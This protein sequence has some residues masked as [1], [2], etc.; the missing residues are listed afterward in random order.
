MYASLCYSVSGHE[1]NMILELTKIDIP[2]NGNI[3]TNSICTFTASLDK[4][5]IDC[6]VAGIRY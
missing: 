4:H 2:L 5:K 3:D 6:Y 1:K